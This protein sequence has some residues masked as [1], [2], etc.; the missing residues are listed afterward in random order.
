MDFAGEPNEPGEHKKTLWALRG[1]RKSKMK[2]W[3]RPTI[4]EQSKRKKRAKNK[5][6]VWVSA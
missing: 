4:K 6:R 5:I 2:Y 1:A 3:V